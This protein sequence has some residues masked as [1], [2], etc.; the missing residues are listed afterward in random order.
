MK[1]KTNG[2]CIFDK[3][4]WAVHE[5][6]NYEQ[7]NSQVLAVKIWKAFPDKKFCQP[8]ANW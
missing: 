3:K 6:R 1:N 5:W 2:I 4:G 7:S 8:F